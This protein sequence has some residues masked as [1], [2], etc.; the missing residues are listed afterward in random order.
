MARILSIGKCLKSSRAVKISLFFICVGLGSIA[1]V[2]LRSPAP[3]REV[4]STCTDLREEDLVLR[5]DQLYPLLRKG[6]TVRIKV[7]YYSCH[8]PQRGE[9]VYY[10]FS[11]LMEPVVRVL[12]A[13]PGDRYGVVPH[14]ERRGWSVKIQGDLMKTGGKDHYFGVPAAAPILKLFEGQ[15]QGTLKPNEVL[16]FSLSMPGDTD[17][18]AFGVANMADMLGRIELSPEKAAELENL[19]R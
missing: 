19:L 7:G 1:Y 9:L 14:S 11:P 10:R 13:L 4:A 5:D 16:V 3:K 2:Y 15:N 8:R 18:G 12:R 17:S 6:E